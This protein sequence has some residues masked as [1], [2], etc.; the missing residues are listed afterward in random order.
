MSDDVVS[1]QAPLPGH[2]SVPSVE[3]LI[4]LWWLL[5]LLPVRL[6]VSVLLRHGDRRRRMVIGGGRLTG[7]VRHA[8]RLLLLLLL[9]LVLLVV[10]S[11]EGGPVHARVGGLPGEHGRVGRGPGETGGTG[12]GHGVGRETGR[13]GDRRV[14]TVPGRGRGRGDGGDGVEVIVVDLLPLPTFVFVFKLQLGQVPS[15]RHLRPGTPRS[16]Q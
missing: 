14:M 11:L 4:E 2:V 3:P 5:R 15:V 16:A 13:E 12:R 7:Q 8:V 9:V 10:V 6:S 1:V